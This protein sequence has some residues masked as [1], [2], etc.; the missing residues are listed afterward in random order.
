MNT[1]MKP[2]IIGDKVASLPIV[3]GGMGIGVSLSKLASAVAKEGGVGV[4]SAAGAGMFDWN[5]KDF[6]YNNIHDLKKEIRKAKK[7]KNGLIGVNIM[8]A[9]TNFD[10]M[11][12]TSLE[13]KVDII[14]AG[15]GLP[16]NLPSYLKGNTYTKLVPIISSGRAA[17][18][19]CKKWLKSFDY[20]PDAFVLEGPDAGG[21]LGFKVEQ[22]EDEAYS[23][24]NVLPEVL[25]SIK[26]YEEQTG[27]KIPIIV[28]GGIY[29]GEDIHY[30]LNNGASAVQ[31]ATRFVTTHEC[32]ASLKF[33]QTYIDAKKEDIT[34][35][36]SP[37]GLPGRAIRNQYTE[38][39]TNGLKHPFT[40]PFDCII[41]CKRELAPYCIS[42]ALVS[43]KKGQMEKG[44][45]F[46][47]T[48][49]Y[50]ATEIVSVKELIDTLKEEYNSAA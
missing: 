41:T 25:E 14:F 46:A 47:G 13:E 5:T 9:L 6:R 31:M 40:C 21:H 8:V 7:E 38:D 15:A 23:L 10:D 34:I 35:I 22:L 3:Q 50:K 27:R 44:F 2:L 33:K 30:F 24:K 20:L 12:T 48:N 45:A 17:K 29:T 49:A 32:D 1:T 16:L 39:V 36:K 18:L 37:V 28:G 43:A 42:K 11:V 26:P 19:L 4:I